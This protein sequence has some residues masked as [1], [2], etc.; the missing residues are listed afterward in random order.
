MTLPARPILETSQR[1][2]E[3]AVVTSPSPSTSSSSSEFPPLHFSFFRTVPSPF[4][5]LA[6]CPSP[7]E[8]GK[9]QTRHGLQTAGSTSHLNVRFAYRGEDPV[10]CSRRWWV[11][12]SLSK[13]F[14]LES[15]LP[16]SSSFSRPTPLTHGAFH[17][18][19]DACI[20]MYHPE[21]PLSSSFSSSSSFSFPTPSRFFKFPRRMYL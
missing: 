10:A 12:Q 8:V 14:N 1:L 18:H 6:T 15:A 19:I 2:A 7:E 5:P 16:P 3:H 11:S 17:V 13:M 20:L 4:P 9:A 21:S